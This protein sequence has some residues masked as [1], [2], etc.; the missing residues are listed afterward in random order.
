MEDI[1][2]LQRLG[3]ARR[4]MVANVSHE[5]RTP[6]TSIRL[7]TDT[8]RRD[9]MDGS[10]RGEELAGK[11]NAEI[12]ALEQM[13]QELL[14]LSMIE[15]GRAEIRLIPVELGE[16]IRTA[17]SRFSEQ[18]ERKSLTI[19]AQAP[20]QLAV[21]ADPDQVGRVLNNLLHN[22]IKFTPTGGIVDISVT[23]QDDWVQL[24]VT[25]TGPGIPE[26]EHA[27]V[28]ERFYQADRA[29]RGGG[30][31]L[32]LAIAKHIVVAHGGEIWAEAPPDQ[33]G[34]RLCFTLPT[35]D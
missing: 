4:D 17:V 30:T 34:A 19:E 8:L 12:E 14:D 3:R 1:S 27:R 6:I 31:G 26:E 20:P 13:A 21:L 33:V 18:A 29:R 35:A 7:L 22:A 9:F 2:E 10:E 5:L 24:S 15:S 28:F 25:D 32:G 23:L 16:I 11:I